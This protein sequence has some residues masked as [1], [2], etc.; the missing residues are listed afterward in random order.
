MPQDKIDLEKVM[1][2][3]IEPILENAMQRY[4]GVSISQMKEDLTQKLKRPWI[5]YTV[6]ISIPFKKAKLNFKKEYLQKLL[7]L[8]FGN[9]SEVARLAGL[10]RRSI[11]RLITETEID[12]EKIRRDMVREYDLKQDAVSHVIG[13]VL[14]N[15]KSILHPQKVEKLYENVTEVSKDLIEELP[16]TPETLEEME[17]EFEKRYLSEALKFHAG[18][19]SATA[20]AI[21]LRYE[22]L[23]RKIKELKIHA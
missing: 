3:K 14:E 4:L 11:H 19:V 2:E 6:D 16:Q 21:G 10:N 12:V 23:H 17:Q 15:Y 7:L 9:V 1:K 8:H 18:N 22:T 13:E 20:R 5:T